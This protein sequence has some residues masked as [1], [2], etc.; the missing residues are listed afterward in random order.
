M[1]N[2]TLIADRTA[3]NGRAMPV[4]VIQRRR[5]LQAMAEAIEPIWHGQSAKTVFLHGPSGA[6]KSSSARHLLQRMQTRSRAVHTA[7]VN[8][9]DAYSRFDLL[10]A[11]VRGLGLRVLQ[12]KASAKELAFRLD[13]ACQAAPCVLALDEVDQ[14]EQKKVLYTLGQLPAG[15]LLVSNDD[16]ALSQ[17]DERIRS[18][19]GP[20][21]RVHFPPYQRPELEDIVA[22][23]AQHALRPDALSNAQ[24]RQIAATA[25]GNAH[26]AIESLRLAAEAAERQNREAVADADVHKAVEQARR[27]VR[28]KRLDRLNAHQKLLYD[29]IKAAGEVPAGELHARYRERADEPLTERAIRNYLHKLEKYGFIRKKGTGRWRTYSSR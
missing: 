12:G 1:R 3:L 25:G 24:I 18:R 16:T 29:L 9:W 26:L 7:Y 28:T 14:L 21:E 8:C 5:Q 27:T 20:M 6:G 4:I 23:R 19:L 22:A 15:L 2:N 17:L 10:R 13:K 11:L